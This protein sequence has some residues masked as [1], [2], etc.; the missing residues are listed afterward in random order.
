MR[1]FRLKTSDASNS[2]R[3]S[4][5]QTELL[6]TERPSAGPVVL[7]CCSSEPVGMSDGS[8]RFSWVTVRGGS[9]LGGVVVAAGGPAVGPEDRSGFGVLV[10]V[11][12]GVGDGVGVG[13]TV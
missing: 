7:T 11:A 10:G 6:A 5:R 1:K 12:V 3:P 2:S 8:S 9:W 4:V 13:L